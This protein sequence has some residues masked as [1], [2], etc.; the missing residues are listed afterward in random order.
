MKTIVTLL[1]IEIIIGAMMISVKMLHDLVAPE[2]KK[3]VKEKTKDSLNTSNLA[4]NELDIN[5]TK[6]SVTLQ[7]EK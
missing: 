1:A 7:K 6:N 4:K 2:D 5:D 3:Q